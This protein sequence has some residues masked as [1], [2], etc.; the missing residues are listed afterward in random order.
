[1]PGFFQRLTARTLGSGTQIVK[2]IVPSVFANDGAIDPAAAASLWE[3]APLPA[4]QTSARIAAD[5]K[6][7]KRETD[8]QSEPVPVR[9]T[10]RQEAGRRPR[11]LQEAADA[12]FAQPETQPVLVPVSQAAAT[13]NAPAA[14]HALWR[15]T[16]QPPNRQ[17][18]PVSRRPSETMPKQAPVIRVT[19][20]RVEVRAEFPPPPAPAAPRPA[21]P[22]PLTLDQY[23]RQRDRGLR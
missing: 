1:M 18:A 20:G 9:E 19:I 11:S 6:P 15:E 23:R 3:Q 22:P 5:T 10:G 17:T 4:E 13:A 12:I 14:A 16:A 7:S 21:A 8:R 2:P